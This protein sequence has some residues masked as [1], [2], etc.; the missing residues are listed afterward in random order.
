MYDDG[1]GDGGVDGDTDIERI[2]VNSLSLLL[3]KKLFGLL[4]HIKIVITCGDQ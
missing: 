4:R 1:G 2:D 3:L